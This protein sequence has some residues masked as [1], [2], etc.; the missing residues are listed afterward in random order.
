[1]SI[2]VTVTRKWSRSGETISKSE[3]ITSDGAIDYDGTVDGSENDLEIEFLLT[4]PAN[5]KV[6][7]MVASTDMTLTPKDVSNVA[8]TAI[9]LNAGIA[10][11][12]T[13]TSGLAN[14]FDGDDVATIHVQNLDADDGALSIRCSKDATPGT[15]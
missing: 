13:Y 1:M 10:F 3:T 8:G 7:Y 15:S 2:S 5:M 4:D 11:E 9:D 6:L 12:W 14:P